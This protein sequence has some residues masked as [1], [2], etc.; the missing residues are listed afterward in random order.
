MDDKHLTEKCL[1]TEPIFKGRLL[2]IYRDDV[3]LP[4]GTTS[5]REYT[6]HPGAVALVPVLP[7]GSILLIRQYRYAAGKVMI[8]I[9]AGKLDPGEDYLIT[10]PRELLEETGYQAGKFTLLGEIDP[11]VGYSDEHM[12]ICLAEELALQENNLD[13]DEFIELLPTALDKAVEMTLNGKITDVKTIIGIQWAERYLTN[14]S[15]P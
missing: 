1:K 15:K 9:P 13:H 12:W 11:C 7:D 6:V 10:A 5:T 4:D 3:E 2:D 14:T 8:E